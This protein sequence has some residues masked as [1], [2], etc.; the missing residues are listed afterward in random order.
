MYMYVNVLR[1]MTV[2]FLILQPTE[3][4]L[5]CSEYVFVDGGGS[6][7]CL[8]RIYLLSVCCSVIHNFM[9]TL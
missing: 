5:A 7:Q 3:S 8:V 4:E 6:G 1:L 2:L 9:F